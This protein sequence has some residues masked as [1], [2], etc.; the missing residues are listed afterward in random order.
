MAPRYVPPIALYKN[1]HT[2]VCIHAHTISRY[3]YVYEQYIH[4]CT[5]Y[6][7]PGIFVHKNAASEHK[8]LIVVHHLTYPQ[9]TMLGIPAISDGFNE[10]RQGQKRKKDHDH[11]EYM[12]C[13]LCTTIRKKGCRVFSRGVEGGHLPPP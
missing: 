5:V 6:V 1:K 4:T 7:H 2:Y 8:P 12:G 9:N 13:G 11:L 10:M 3:L